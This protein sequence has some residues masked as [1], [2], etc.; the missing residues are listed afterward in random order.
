VRLAS[1]DPAAAPL[2]DPNYWS[3]PEDRRRS[4]EGLRLAR[5][6]M[7]QPALRRFVLAERLPGPAKASDEELFAYGCANAK[8]DYHPVGTCR[9]GPASDPM[10]VV[11]PELALIGLAGLRVADASVM[12]R[13]PSS[14]TNAPAIMVAEKAADHILGRIVAR[15][16]GDFHADSPAPDRRH[17]ENRDAESTADSA[18]R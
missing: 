7:S 12:P 11:T 18:V 2:I 3:E 8:T 10:S 5:E 9:I 17:A 14:N 6:I 13:V 16:D 1:A 15:T 4:I